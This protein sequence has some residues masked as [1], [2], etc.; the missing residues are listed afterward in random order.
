MTQTLYP[1]LAAMPKTGITG[2]VKI[3][4]GSYA[5]ATYSVPLTGNVSVDF[6]D[7]NVPIVGGG[8]LFK[9]TPGC[10]VVIRLGGEFTPSFQNFD[11]GLT[12][13]VDATLLDTDAP[14]TVILVKPNGYARSIVYAKTQGGIVNAIVIEPNMTVGSGLRHVADFMLVFG[15]SIV[16][17]LA[18]PSASPAG[19]HSLDDNAGTVAKPG[20]IC[21]AFG[22][23]LTGYSAPNGAFTQGDP[24]L[25]ECRVHLH[26][27]RR[28]TT[29]NCGD[30]GCHDSKAA[31]SEAS[32][33]TAHS[34]GDRAVSQHFG[35][36]VAYGNRITQAA[37]PAGGG[38]GKAYQGSGTLVVRGDVV[39]LEVGAR[40]A[41]SNFVASPGS[42]PLSTYPRVGDLAIHGDVDSTGAPVTGP[43]LASGGQGYT[44]KVTA[45]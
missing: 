23:T 40:L 43:V 21:G 25:G 12:G 28:C 24:S 19:L 17:G 41:V 8:Y 37:V 32:E 34:I 3:A 42:G 16:G 1:S 4:P 22:T 11:G 15:G 5:P 39:D 10:Q 38:Q 44:P 30:S 9:V 36:G 18:A 29:G 6:R 7:V 2:D 13:I 27:T 14:A 31:H 35:E 45:D 26:I 20:T 33:N